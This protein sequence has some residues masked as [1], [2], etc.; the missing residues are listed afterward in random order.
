[1]T[2]LFYGYLLIVVLYS[3]LQTCC[4][5]TIIAEC[6]LTASGTEFRGAVNTT[7][8][9]LACQLWSLQSP[10]SHNYTNI[11]M[12]PDKTLAQVHTK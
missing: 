10:H 3:L 4:N 12:F 11:N 9:G 5:L 6:K 1:M 7:S 2:M 8:S